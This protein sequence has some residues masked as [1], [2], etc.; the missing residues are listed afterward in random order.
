GAS[1]SAVCETVQWVENTLAK[2]KTFKL[3]GKKALRK[4]ENAI[5]YIAAGVAEGPIRR[6]EKGQKEHYSGKKRHAIKAQAIIEGKSKKVL[7]ARE[8]KGGVHDFQVY[9]DAIG[10]SV[11]ASILIRADLGYLGI[12]K[13]HENSRIPKKGSRLHKLNRR[14]KAYNKRLARERAAIERINAKIKTFKSMACLYR[15]HCGRHLLRMSLICGIINR[16]LCI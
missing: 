5:E 12:E 11:K 8:A 6:P 16:E 14:D 4:A 7:G 3:P 10:K 13:L 9:K 15:N 2:D 1:K